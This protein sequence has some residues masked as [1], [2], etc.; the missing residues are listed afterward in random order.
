MSKTSFDFFFGSWKLISTLSSDLQIIH[1]HCRASSSFI[2]ERR[3]NSIESKI[4]WSEERKK[5]MILLTKNVKFVIRWWNDGKKVIDFHQHCCHV[6][7]M[8]MA[9]TQN[10]PCETIHWSIFSS[11]FFL[12]FGFADTFWNIILLYIL[13]IINEF[14][15]RKSMVKKRRIIQIF[16]IV[17]V[18]LYDNFLV[19]VIIIIIDQNWIQNKWK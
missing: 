8:M 6:I 19:F 13:M 17:H 9:Q 1:Q 11:C 10:V 7:M 12:H 3:T 15:A 18:C 14:K 16:I 4:N 5:M 2:N